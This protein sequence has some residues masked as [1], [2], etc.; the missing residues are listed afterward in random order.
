MAVTSIIMKDSSALNIIIVI[1]ICESQ[2]ICEQG[3]ITGILQNAPLLH[4][5]SASL[6]FEAVGAQSKGP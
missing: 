2:S 3:V 4:P 1:K 6:A 5:P